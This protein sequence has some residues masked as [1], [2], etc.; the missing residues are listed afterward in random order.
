[1][2]PKVALVSFTSRGPRDEIMRRTET[3]LENKDDREA[4]IAGITAELFD[5][6]AKGLALLAGKEMD[7]LGMPYE[8]VD[9][10]DAGVQTMDQS[11][12]QQSD[13]LRNLQSLAESSTHVL[14]VVPMWK[15]Q[16]AVSARATLRLP[17]S[18]SLNNK[19]S[20]FIFVLRGSAHSGYGRPLMQDVMLQA[21]CW[22]LPRIVEAVHSDFEAENLRSDAIASGIS[23]MVRELTVS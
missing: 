4:R 16:V 7:A 3:M 8:W 22:I 5:L 19:V 15:H 20:G 12:F 11:A 14:W 17:S 9:F 2:I 18:G 1:M 23:T 13:F 6:R 10:V 21:R